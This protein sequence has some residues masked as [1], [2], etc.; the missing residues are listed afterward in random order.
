M[1]EIDVSGGRITLDK[2]LNDLDELVIDFVKVLDR[3]GIRYVLVSGYVAILFGR[4]RSS[5][6]IDVIVEKMSEERFL[7]LSEEIR[8]SFDCIITDSPKSAYENY[9]S[10][11]ASIRFARKGEFVPNIE[12]MFPKAESLDN[13]VLE[14]RRQ[15]VLNGI[16]LNISPIEL[17]IPYKLFLGSSKDIEDARHLYKLFEDAL[18]RALLAQFLIKLDKEGRFNKYLA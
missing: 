4:S 12:F 1:M 15:V 5:E 9:L 8:T 14:N 6:D 17:Q 18:D 13:W 7:A 2:E 3:S 11:R 16:H 10:Q